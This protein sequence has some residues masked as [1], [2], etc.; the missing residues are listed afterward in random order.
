LSKKKI[1]KI[2]YLVRALLFPLPHHYHEFL[3]SKISVPGLEP[4]RTAFF[5]R[6]LSCI[7]TQLQLK[8]KGALWG[9][10]FSA[11]ATPFELWSHSKKAK[12]TN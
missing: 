5:M 6:H 1:I 3:C 4:K 8:P 10:V 12:A 9:R 7:M 2:K 11:G